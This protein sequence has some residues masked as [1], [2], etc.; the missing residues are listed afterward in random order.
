M[1]TRRSNYKKY[2]KLSKTR[3]HKRHHSKRYKRGGQ[4]PP[5]SFYSIPGSKPVISSEPIIEEDE[6]VV[7]QVSPSSYSDIQEQQRD[8]AADAGQ[9]VTDTVN[10]LKDVFNQATQTL[11][12]TLTKAKHK[13]LEQLS[14]V[15]ETAQNAAQK[16]SDKIKDVQASTPLLQQQNQ[17][18]I[19]GGNRKTKRHLRSNR[20]RKFK[21]NKKFPR[22][23]N[24]TFYV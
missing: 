17:Q 9:K 7:Q 3:R 14:K 24:L 5:V 10:Q 4:V 15:A 8:F 12:D 19:T 21:N 23:K 13:T 1:K 6:P 18:F 16:A 20:S 2:N 11:K 22:H